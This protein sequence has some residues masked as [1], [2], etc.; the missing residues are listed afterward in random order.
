MEYF[1]YTSDTIPEGLGFSHF[2]QTHLSWLA[3]GALIVFICC[4]LYRQLSEKSRGIFRKTVA[5]LLVADEL[6]KLIP[7]LIMGCFD[8][9]YLPFQLC[10]INMFL[11]AWHAWKP[12]KLLDNFLYTVCIPGALAAMLFPTWTKLPFVNYMSFHS[13]SV[14]ILLIL[15]PVVLTAAGDIKPQLKEVPKCLLLLAGLAAFALVLNLWW[16]TNFMFLMYASK[17]NP[18]KWFE[19]AWGNHLLGFPVL[20]AAVIIVMHTPWILCRKLKKKNPKI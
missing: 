4:L 12:S 19:I 9:S 17:G 10:S 11:I 6:F 1:W 20:I 13:I 2:D 7:M 8:L 5:L 18:L 14:H 15:Y 16:N 3:G